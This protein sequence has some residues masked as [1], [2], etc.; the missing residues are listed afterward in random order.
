MR[1]WWMHGTEGRKKLISS[2]LVFIFSSSGVRVI[3][4]L[5][6]DVAVQP[7]PLCRR[8]G[9]SCF[10]F[11][12]QWI[13]NQLSGSI[14]SP[15]ASSASRFPHAQKLP[16]WGCTP[17]FE[18]ENIESAQ[19]QDYIKLQGR[20][21]GETSSRNKQRAAGDPSVLSW[22]RYS[23]GKIR[24]KQHFVPHAPLL[25]V[26]LA[27]VLPSVVKSVLWKISQAQARKVN[28]GLGEMGFHPAV[29]TDSPG[30]WVYSHLWHCIPEQSQAIHFPSK[31]PVFPC[32]EGQYWLHQLNWHFS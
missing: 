13:S 6:L 22:H 18:A 4:P 12:H 16:M 28:S 11:W 20:N 23:G 8:W 29:C 14:R 19:I 17:Q 27:A 9:N 10:P 15:N 32:P 24:N 1:C 31:I 3:A 21:A 2:L 5:L 26:V 30:F 7:L 25:T